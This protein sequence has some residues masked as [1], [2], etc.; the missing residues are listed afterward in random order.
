MLGLLGA[1]HLSAILAGF[2]SPADPFAQHRDLAFAP[3]MRIRLV[4]AGGAW[5]WRPFVYALVP[6]PGTLDQYDEDRSRRHPVRF[7]VRGA[8][9]EIAG[10]L[11]SD[12]HLFGSDSGT[13]IFLF[14]SDD[15]GRD[16]FSRL[17]FGAQVS[18]FA[19][20][21]GAT[22]SLGLGLALGILAGY[23]GGWIDELIMR[24]AELFLALPW[25]YLLFAVRM[26][27]P[28]DMPSSQAFLLVLGVIAIVGWARP[29]RLVRG[30]VLS[31]RSREYVLAAAC[32]GGSDAYLFRRHVL[33]QTTGIVLTLAAVLVPQ[34][35]LAE[36]T[37]SFFGLG[38]TEPVPSWGN[39]LASLQRY[40]VLASYWWMFLPGAVMIPVFLLYY[41]VAD[42]LH[43]RSPT[44][45]T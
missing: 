23:Y 9:Y 28:L 10:V 19:G 37:L 2:L 14:G 43:Q 38:V 27:L 8:R 16:L 34:F 7:F 39:M 29:A 32:L 6:R 31:A 44:A 5:S 26:A 17:L 24:G 4:D 45:G 40:Q 22:L 20:L 21:L 12:R 11:E 3:P 35:V 30:V 41:A 1:V 33:P 15:Y 36:V 13:P 18:L 25:F 42:A